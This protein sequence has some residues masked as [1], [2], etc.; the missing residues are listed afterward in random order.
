MDGDKGEMKMR[1]RTGDFRA[2]AGRSQHEF[3]PFQDGRHIG[4]GKIK[5]AYRA[6]LLAV[7]VLMQVRHGAAM[8]G[9]ADRV[10]LLLGMQPVAVER[11]ERPGQAKEH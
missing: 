7:V 10:A 11:T 5:R 3:R 8:L 2:G 1:R 6:V 9:A 4:Y